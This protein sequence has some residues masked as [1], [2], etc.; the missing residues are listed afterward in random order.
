VPEHKAFFARGRPAIFALH[1]FDVC[2]ANPNSD[3]LDKYCSVLR[4]RLRDIF[5][6][7]TSRLLRF[8]RYCFHRISP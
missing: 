7:C 2:P 8:Y 5:K 6:M 3:R 1:D 4:I